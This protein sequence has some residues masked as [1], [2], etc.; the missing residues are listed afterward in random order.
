MLFFYFV[1]QKLQTCVRPNARLQ[2][3]QRI[4]L[5]TTTYAK[6]ELFYISKMP[7]AMRAPSCE[8]LHY[9]IMHYLGLQKLQLR[10]NKPE[11]ELAITISLLD[12][13]NG[14]VALVT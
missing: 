14:R 13:S 5:P 9:Q 3:K 4:I 2:G 8:P 7:L 6:T 1:W 10:L 11:F 12:L